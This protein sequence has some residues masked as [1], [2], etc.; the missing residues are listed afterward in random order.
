MLCLDRKKW[1]HFYFFV[2]LTR[3]KNSNPLDL[4]IIIP[5]FNE[6]DN[7]RPLHEEITDSCLKLEK[8]YE[9]LFVDDGSWDDTFVV[10]KKI[11]K[12]DPRVKIIRLRKNFGQTAALA[13]GFDNSRGDIVITLDADLQNDPKDF[14][15]LIQKI[16]QGYDIVSG[17][18]IKRKD[19]FFTRRLPSIIANWLISRITRVKLHDYGCSLKAFRKDVV[20][21]I[22]LYGELHRFIPALASTIG[23][24][25]AEVK[26]N[27]RPRRFG[28]SKY[29]LWR[30]T[31]VI[32]DLFTVK[33]LLTYSTRPLQIFGLFGL[34][35][36][37]TGVI[38]AFWLGYIRLIK[39][40]GI[41][42]RP[43]LLLAIMLIV[44]GVQFI[45]LGLLAEMTARAY[46]ESVNRRIYF[47]RE[48]I[49]SDEDEESG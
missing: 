41:S 17:W 14:G 19:K 22:H 4:S 46:H 28:K 45:T 27:H 16:N 49:S 36:G 3:M 38:L 40:E 44:I 31:K 24:S 23:V 35:S 12:Q 37:L 26:V 25:I 18:R 7:L 2:I 43:L 8:N 5:V 11:Q 9:I 32:L 10:L 6:A 42:G 34:I 39:M 15:I 20:K 47:I 13:A 1:K 30:F 33:F 48:I 29:R 21:N